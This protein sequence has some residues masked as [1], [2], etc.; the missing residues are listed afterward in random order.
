MTP[1][2]PGNVARDASFLSTLS[3]IVT[4][5]LTRLCIGLAIIAIIAFLA[6]SWP[7]IL[8]ALGCFT[9]GEFVIRQFRA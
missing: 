3:S 7:L 4:R 2:H 6:Q 9:V 5:G 1:D 8:F